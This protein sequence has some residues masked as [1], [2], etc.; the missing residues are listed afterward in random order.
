[1]ETSSNTEHLG[2]IPTV[3]EYK[4][5]FLA[6]RPALRSKAG[7]S[8]PMEM[9]KANYYAPGHTVTA[10][11]LAET[12]RL[13]SYKSANLAYGKFAKALCGELGRT[14]KYNVAILVSF[15]GTRPDGE[16]VQWTML[17]QVVAALEELGWVKPR[18]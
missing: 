15:D 12:V 13:A 7:W 5:G 18:S 17:P 6:C 4:E 11:E 3:A 16:N 14:P 1:M 9:L 10:S 2:D 8:T